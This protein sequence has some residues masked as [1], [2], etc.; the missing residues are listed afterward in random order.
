MAAERITLTVPAKGEYAK[1][2]RMTASALVS[3]LP[4]ST[5]W[6]AERSTVSLPPFPSAASSQASGE[7]IAMSVLAAVIRSDSSI[8]VVFAPFSSGVSGGD[9]QPVKR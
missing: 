7:P 1:T 3:A 8:R 9:A 6:M 2:V 4:G 5:F